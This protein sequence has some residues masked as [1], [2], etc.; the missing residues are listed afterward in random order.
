MP[1]R[2]GSS[3][4]RQA[5]CPRLGLDG[6]GQ[7]YVAC[8]RLPPTRWARLHDQCLWAG[9][10]AGMQALR[11]PGPGLG[12][13]RDVSARHVSGWAAGARGGGGEEV[14]LEGAGNAGGGGGCDS[15]WGEWVAGAE[16]G[17]R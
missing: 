12:G 4:C 10:T 6:G 8:L 14:R 7:A 13:G 2:R 5:R 15:E 16:G 17:G 1:D 9:G 3:A 11:R